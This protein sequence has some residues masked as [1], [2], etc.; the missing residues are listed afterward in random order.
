M[1]P[2]ERMQKMLANQEIDYLPSQID[3]T[4]KLILKM[5]KAFGFEPENVDEYAGN[6]IKYAFSFGNVEEYMHDKATLI[7]GE[8]LGFARWDRDH[9]IVYDR[10]GC[11][12]DRK[13]EGVFCTAHPLE[14]LDK[15]KDYQFPDAK[16]SQMLRMAH[17]TV[18]KYKDT[19][20]IIGFQHIGLFERAWTL[21]GYENFLMGL[22]P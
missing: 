20:Y 10:F 14:D 4:P 21:R 17:D 12:W 18:K 7:L 6:N 1:K 15:Y 5:S 13:I 3:F 11:G 19:Y 2:R 16:N 8:E 9:E 22:L